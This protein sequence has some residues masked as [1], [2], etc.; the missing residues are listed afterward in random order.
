[1]RAT[2]DAEKLK[3]DLAAVECLQTEEVPAGVS[4]ANWA[5]A[6]CLQNLCAGK[7]PKRY[8]HFRDNISRMGSRTQWEKWWAENKTNFVVQPHP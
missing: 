5:M 3:R 4:T 7:P 6:W 1:V 2:F 8:R